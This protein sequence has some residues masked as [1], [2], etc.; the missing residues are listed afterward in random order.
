MV[1]N[2]YEPV[3]KTD[4]QYKPGAKGIDGVYRNPSPPPDYVVTEVKYNTSQLSK[5]LADGTNQ[6]DDRWLGSRLADK[7]GEVEAELI[8]EAMDAGTVESG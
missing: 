3:G 2:G 6:M 5:R 7:V 8:H 1:R 4:G